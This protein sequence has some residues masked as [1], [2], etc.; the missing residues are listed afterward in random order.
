MKEMNEWHRIGEQALEMVM[1]SY[2]INENS[3]LH[4]M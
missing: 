2:Q 3:C 1:V 4:K